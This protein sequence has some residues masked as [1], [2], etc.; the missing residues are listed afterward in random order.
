MANESDSPQQPLA[1][2][3][4]AGTSASRYFFMFLVGLF[5]GAM[6]I[7]MVLRTVDARKTWQ[8]RFPGAVMHVM[9][10]HGAQLQAKVAAN[11][12]EPTDILPHAQAL[13]ML[14]NDIEPAFPGLVDDARFATHAGNMRA[15]LDQVIADPLRGCE[16]SQAALDAINGGCRACHQEF[17]G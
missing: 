7:V 14:A 8:D 17:R 12:C 15:A 9:N 3:A 1:P 6:A 11:R 13:R 4:H 2:R 10:S 5:V 16:A